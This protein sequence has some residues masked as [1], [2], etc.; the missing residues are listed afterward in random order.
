[1]RG[2]GVAVYGTS[3]VTPILLQKH[4]DAAIIPCHV[5]HHSMYPIEGK[6]FSFQ[7]FFTILPKG[8]KV[9]TRSHTTGLLIS[10]PQVM[11]IDPEVMR[12]ASLYAQETWDNLKLPPTYETTHQAK[13]TRLVPL[14]DMPYQ[15][16]QVFQAVSMVLL[17][18]DVDAALHTD[19]W[20][21]MKT[22]DRVGGF[23]KHV[24]YPGCPQHYFTVVV[25]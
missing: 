6:V 23:S 22:P 2:N 18:N 7:L 8:E 24:D 21:N 19:I 20:I 9:R 14:P 15:F 12:C 5:L 11:H 1:M 3:S 16:R 17:A 13:Y 4:G 25:V 10:T